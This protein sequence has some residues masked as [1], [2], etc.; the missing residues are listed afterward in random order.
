R[1]PRPRGPGAAD[2]LQ[3]EDAERGEHD[4]A[5]VGAVGPAAALERA[6]EIAPGEGAR[7]RPGGGEHE[8]RALDLARVV[9]LAR[10]RAHVLERSAPAVP[11]ARR[12]SP[13]RRQAERRPAGVELRGAL[14][15]GR[16]PSPVGV[17]GPLQVAAR[18]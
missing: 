13:A 11:D 15:G 10:P 8:D 2:G 7:V 4:A 3:G 6:Y 12:T 18:G 17:L 16:A 14:A 5:G 1:A 9:E